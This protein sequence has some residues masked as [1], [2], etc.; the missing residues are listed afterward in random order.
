MHKS[1]NSFGDISEE[2]TDFAQ[3][4]TPLDVF[5]NM[6]FGHPNPED[7]VGLSF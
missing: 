3:C 6:D 1:C 4:L 5:Y 2:M 7:Y